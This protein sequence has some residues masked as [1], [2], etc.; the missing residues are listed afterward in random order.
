MCFAYA[1]RHDQQCQQF[2]ELLEEA[3][4]EIHQEPVI[5]QPG[6]QNGGRQDPQDA[7]HQEGRE[8]PPGVELALW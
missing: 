1:T 5:E 7:T 6:F 8:H 3:D 4:A 2:G